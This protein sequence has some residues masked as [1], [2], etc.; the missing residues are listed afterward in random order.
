MGGGVFSR[1]DRGRSRPFLVGIVRNAARNKR[2][3]HH[4]ARA[5]DD[6]DSIQVPAGAISTERLVASAEGQ[7]RLRACVDQLCETQEAVV[8]LRL[9]E[10]QP[11]EDIATALGIRRS[12]VDVLLHRAKASLRVCMTDTHE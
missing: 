5:H 11:G 8:M 7:V 6:I 3:R 1:G 2:R 12:Y 4:A 10:H 9:L